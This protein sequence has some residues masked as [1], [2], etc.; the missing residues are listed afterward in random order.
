MRKEIT[1]S[2]HVGSERVEHLTEDYKEQLAKRLSETMSQYYTA[3]PE[4]Y[5]RLKME[6]VKNETVVQEDK[7]PGNETRF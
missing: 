3:R 7:A 4:E 1:V 6:E 5:L 2:F